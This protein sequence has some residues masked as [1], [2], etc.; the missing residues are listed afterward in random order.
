[1]LLMI[2][3]SQVRVL[4]DPPSS[5]IFHGLM[6]SGKRDCP[7]PIVTWSV[8]RPMGFMGLLRWDQGIGGNWSCVQ[9]TA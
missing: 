7:F 5:N 4:A 3:C 1:M 6:A 8:V 2:P 9:V